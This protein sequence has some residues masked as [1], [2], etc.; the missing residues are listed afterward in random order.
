RGRTVARETDPIKP[1]DRQAIRRVRPHPS[2][3]VRGL[4]ALQLLTGTRAGELLDLRATDIDTSGPVWEY[5]PAGH[6][7]AHHGHERVIYFGPEAKRILRLFMQPGRPLDRPLFS[8][9]EAAAEAK[10]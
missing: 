8:P 4:I 7:T 6:K 5:K 10:R 1:V 3:P 9:R 2:Q